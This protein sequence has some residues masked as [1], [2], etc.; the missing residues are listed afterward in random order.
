MA[1][2]KLQEARDLL[3]TASEGPATFPVTEEQYYLW[4]STWILPKI[5]RLVPELKGT[6]LP[7]VSRN[8]PLTARQEK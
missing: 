3:E 2:T 7:H 8:R 1:R 5:I 6:P 4:V